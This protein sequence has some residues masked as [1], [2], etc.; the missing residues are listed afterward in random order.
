[1]T[2]IRL[3][4]AL[5]AALSCLPGAALA[6]VTAD[7]VLT[8]MMAPARALG[9]EIAMPQAREGRVVTV[10]RQEM[11]YVLPMGT[12]VARMVSSGMTLTEEDD[13]TVAM[14]YSDPLEMRLEVTMADRGEVFAATMTYDADGMQTRAS[15]VPGQVAYESAVRDARIALTDLDIPGETGF[16]MSLEGTMTGTSRYEITEGELVRMTLSSTSERMQFDSRMRDAQGSVSDSGQT[17]TGGTTEM[18]MA[19]PAGGVDL[20]NLDDALRAGLSVVVRSAG[21]QVE[22]LSVAQ[23]LG[24]EVRQTSS[25]VMERNDL[26]L[27]ADGLTLDAVYADAAFEMLMPE[28]MPFALAGGAARSVM[29]ARLPVVRTDGAVP[30]ELRLTL[31]DMT[32]ADGIWSLFDPEGQLPRDPMSLVLDMSG[33]AALAR[34]PL[35][36]MAMMQ[37][38]LA[39]DPLG[40]VE[41]LRLNDFLLRAAGAEVTGQGAVEIDNDDYETF[42]GMPAPTGSLDLRVTG[43]NGLLDTLVGMGLLPEEQAMGARM[44]LGMIGR[45]GEGEDVITSTIEITG[46]GQILANGQRLR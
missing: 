35:D 33:E 24:T 46:D 1:M 28:T 2:D 11:T 3:S 29:R 42:P 23:T 45:P 37:V 25:Y 30:V 15:G 38:G 34:D 13:G 8:N 44:M 9:F 43:A 7:D 12:G 18:E 5:L 20:M 41:A 21:M 40:T 16:E 6:D 32:L 19:V 39:E 26:T 22:G 31:E 36:I 10:A 17:M 27:D 14:V 4:P